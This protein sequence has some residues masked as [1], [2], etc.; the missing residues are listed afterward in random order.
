LRIAPPGPGLQTSPERDLQQFRGEEDK[1]LNTY[2][3][4]DKQKGTVHLPIDEAIKSVVQK[5]ILGFPK[6]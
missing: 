6:E 3:W 5:G 4:I 1:R 2:Y